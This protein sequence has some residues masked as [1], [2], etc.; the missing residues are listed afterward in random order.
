VGA[1]D[2]GSAQRTVSV[3]V[4]RDRVEGP[5]PYVAAFLAIVVAGLVFG[6][7]WAMRKT[8]GMKR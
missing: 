4:G 7:L 8:F 5:N 2:T 3:A 1:P 6:L